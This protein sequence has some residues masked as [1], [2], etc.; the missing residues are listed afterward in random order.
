M[1]N[2]ATSGIARVVK[3]SSIGIEAKRMATLKVGKAASSQVCANKRSRLQAHTDTLRDDDVKGWDGV[4]K[5]LA[6]LDVAYGGGASAKAELARRLVQLSTAGLDG[7][8]GFYAEVSEL[9]R[10][11]PGSAAAGTHFGA[12]PIEK[13]V[14]R[15]IRR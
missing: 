10:N 15:G 14:G 11:S 13:D 7:G 2:P 4:G 5:F 8:T 3:F 6:E 12:M 9:G 1:I